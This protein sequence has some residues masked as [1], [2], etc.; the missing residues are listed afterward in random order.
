MA[1]TVQFGISNL[2]FALRNADGTYETP[3]MHPGADNLSISVEDN[4]SN[5]IS[6]DN[7]LYYDGSGAASLTGELTVARFSDWYREKI[8]GYIVEGGGLGEGQGE[9]AEFAMLF[10]AD[11][12]GGG[13]R[14]VWYGCTSGQISMTFATTSY[15]G[16]I[17]EATEAAT[18]TGKLVELPNGNK[19]RAF[20]C[21]KG[22]ANYD[23]F[24]DA[25]YYPVTS[26]G[27]GDD[28]G[29][30]GDDG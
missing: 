1:T 3:V 19:R 8:L 16:T 10:E 15:D 13:R 25:V 12:N 23:N 2:A 6:K 7:G 22:S 5:K 24:F 21:E 4:D 29:D 26:G 20:S 11:G 14:F 28:D 9:M 27:D 18:I 17:T 30:D